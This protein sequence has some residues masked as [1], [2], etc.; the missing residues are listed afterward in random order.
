MNRIGS[1]IAICVATCVVVGLAQ[2]ISVSASASPPASFR[3]ASGSS[4]QEGKN[5]R[6]LGGTPSQNFKSDGRVQVLEFFGFGCP[7]C[8]ALDPKLAAWDLQNSRDIELTR[9][10][11]AWSPDA[12][13]YARLYY[14]LVALGRSDLREKVFEAIHARS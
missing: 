5:Y 6:D 8:A 14:T 11:T 12:Q 10:P 13:A 2:G 9:V 3:G 4:W 1:C 7:H